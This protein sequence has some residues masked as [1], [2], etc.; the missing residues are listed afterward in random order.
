MRVQTTASARHQQHLSRQ[1][2]SVLYISDEPV[3]GSVV[4]EE[5]EPLQPPQTQ[6][7]IL[8]SPRH[9]LVAA[10]A[11]SKSALPGWAVRIG[12]ALLVFWLLVLTLFM[13]SHILHD[14][15]G[16]AGKGAAAAEQQVLQFPFPLN[17]SA[18]LD[19]KIQQHR[20]CCWDRARR[21]LYCEGTFATIWDQVGHSMTFHP[22]AGSPIALSDLHGGEC[23]LSC[24]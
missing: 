23:V 13:L 18:S 2:R 12:L 14:A 20:I 1:R 19:L 11:S 9:I 8:D 15:G 24:K 6:E 16:R 10:A 21:F 4:D 22:V 5:R 17:G 3:M 7:N